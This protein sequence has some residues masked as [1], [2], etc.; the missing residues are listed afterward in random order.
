MI[1]NAHNHWDEFDELDRRRKAARDRHQRAFSE[2]HVCDR[3]FAD[4]ESLR[5]WR[6]YCETTRSL[7]ESIDQL[8][9]LVWKLIG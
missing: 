3:Q 7:E 5:A 9:R 6:A 2:L 8:E 1:A 4:A